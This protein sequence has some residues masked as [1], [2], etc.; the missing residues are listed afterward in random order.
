M[1]LATWRIDSAEECFNGKIASPS[2]SLVGAVEDPQELLRADL[3][4]PGPVVA[5]WDPSLE[6]GT[7]RVIDTGPWHLD[8]KTANMPTRAVTGPFWVPGYGARV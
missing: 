8:G 5:S 6:P 2:L 1:R 3:P 4:L 7:D